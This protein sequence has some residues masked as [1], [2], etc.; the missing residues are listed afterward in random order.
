MPPVNAG[1][2]AVR[3]EGRELELKLSLTHDELQ[4]LHASR[5]LSAVTVGE[6]TTRN[7]RS[8]YFDTP[9][10]RLKGADVS[11]RVR[12]DGTSW[13]QTVKCGTNIA[14]GVSHPTELETVVTQPE[15][16]LAAIDHCKLGR[17]IRR[18]IQASLLEPAFQVDVTRITRQI[19]TQTGDLELALDEG[20]VSAG[21]LEATLCEAELELKSGDPACLLETAT[22]LFADA[23]LRFSE[24]SKAQRGYDLIC[25][26]TSECGRPVH[27]RPVEFEEGATCGDAL[28][29]VIRSAHQHILANRLVVLG[30][31]DSEGAHQL[32]VGLRR[33][34]TVLSAFGPLIDLPSTAELKSHAKALAAIVGEL[35]DADVLIDT[36]YAPVASSLEDHAG[37]API[38]EALQT[39]RLAQRDAVRSALQGKHWSALQLHFALWPLAIEKHAPLQRPVAKYA[40]KAVQRAWRRVAK[41]GEHLGDLTEEQRHEMRKDLKR[42]RYTAEF[43]NSH[44][45]SAALRP[46]TKQLKELQD[47]FGYLNDVAQARQLEEVVERHCPNNNACHRL[48]GYTLGWHTAQAAKSRDSV[49]ASWRRLERTRQFWR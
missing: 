36:I 38:K 22:R 12:S 15:P 21:G 26:R 35:R 7:L 47:T 43:F 42:F 5:A 24:V 40:D 9:D 30:S 27:A 32:R 2:R 14:N 45:G 3:A 34:R 28:L 31:D 25:G 49:Q 11:L 10:R 20:R 1:G 33:L 44:Y 6:P 13:V 8:I 23:P 4:R 17:K 19:H 41:R 39:Y 37:R 16:D 46:F 48:A 29:A 18:L